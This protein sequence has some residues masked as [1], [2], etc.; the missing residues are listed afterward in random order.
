MDHRVNILASDGRPGLRSGWGLAISFGLATAVCSC[1]P[2]QEK[3]PAPGADWLSHM[4]DLPPRQKPDEAPAA[5][6]GRIV[7]LAS[8]PKQRFSRGEPIPLSFEIR[9]NSDRAVTIWHSGFWPN[10]VIKVRG[11]DGKE[12]ALTPSGEERRRAFRPESPRRK[13]V[14]IEIKAGD[15]SIKES[16]IDLNDLYDLPPG[17]YTCEITYDDAQAPTPLHIT[18]APIAFQKGDI[19]K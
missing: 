16:P 9:N 8:L 1:A 10:H 6:Q 15:S 2:T 11:Q 5:Q 18:S 3:G 14:P 12:P 13:N 7:A 19:P 17:S 4:D